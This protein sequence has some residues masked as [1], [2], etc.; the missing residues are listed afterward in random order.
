MLHARRQPSC[1]LELAQRFAE[2]GI[3]RVPHGLRVPAPVRAVED[4]G[5]H[6]ARPVGGEIV[7]DELDVLVGEWQ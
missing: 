5:A 2:R 7:G 4:V 3:V 6:I 1:P